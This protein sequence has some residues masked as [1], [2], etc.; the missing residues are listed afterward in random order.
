MVPSEDLGR[1]GVAKML[2]IFG[3]PHILLIQLI[4]Q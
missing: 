3:Q 1:R 2:Q 4:M